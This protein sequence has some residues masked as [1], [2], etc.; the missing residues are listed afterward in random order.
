MNRAKDETIYHLNLKQKNRDENTGVD[1]MQQLSVNLTITLPE[2][3]VLITK[4]EYEELN[5]EKLNGVYWSMSDLENKVGKKS[6]WIKDK[7]LYP[8]YFR[9]TL[10][11]ANGG[12]VY[13]PKVKGETWTFH[14]KKMAAFLD[15]NFYLIFK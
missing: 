13:Y 11:I 1:I 5:N 9:K 8:P 6:E 15:D 2:D 3:S 7:I 4:V 12:F 10:D 14:A